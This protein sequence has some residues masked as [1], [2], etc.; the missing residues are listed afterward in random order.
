[1]KKEITNISRNDHT[2]ASRLVRGKVRFLQKGNDKGT[3]SLQHEVLWKAT[4]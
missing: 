4:M 3:A 2:E 1:M